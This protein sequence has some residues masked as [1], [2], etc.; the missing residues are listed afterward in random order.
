MING[1]IFSRKVVAL[2]Q[3]DLRSFKEGTMIEF[4][5]VGLQEIDPNAL[6]LTPVPAQ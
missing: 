1:D 2:C 5:L 3:E 4:R 6:I